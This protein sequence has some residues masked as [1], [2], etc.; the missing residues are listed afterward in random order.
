MMHLL[1]FGGA[2]TDS[3]ANEAAPGVVDPGWTLNAQNRYIAPKKLKCVWSTVLNDTLTAAR[4]NAPSLR[5]LGLPEIYPGTVS[6][7]PAASPALAIWREFGP[8]IQATEGFGI[9]TSNGASTIDRVH[10]G[11]QVRD[12]FNPVPAGKRFTITGTS[13]QT[14][15]LDEWTTGTITLNQE[16]PYGTYSVAGMACVCNDAYL[17]RLVF[18]GNTYWRPGCPVVFTY[19]QFDPVQLCRNGNLGEMGQFI[20]TQPPQ[21]ELIGNAAGAETAT[22]YLDLVAVNVPGSM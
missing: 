22:V 4:I 9:D 20:S 11:L 7:D 16:L 21:L 15:L 14:L 17:A 2:K 6:D 5:N 19:G 12:S 1:A 13:T 8:E 18:P 3:V 10:A